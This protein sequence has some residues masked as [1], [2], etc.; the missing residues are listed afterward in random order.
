MAV[1]SIIQ[2][3]NQFYH[4]TNSNRPAIKLVLQDP[5]YEIKDHQ[6]L[7]RLSNDGD[8]I[9]FVSDPE[10]LLAIDAGT[11]VVTAFLPVQMP[12]VQVIADLFS[13]DPTEGPAAIICDIMTVDVEKREYSLSDRASPA[14]ARFLTNH[15]EKAEDGFDDHG[16]EDELM[17]DAYGD[18][19]ENRFYWLNWM[20]LWVRKFDTN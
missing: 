8:N 7:K 14:V 11:L 12:L 13:K 16:L 9:S 4:Q 15:Y 6:I 19:W 20:D 1:F 5:N 3:L 18:D 2:T 10:G 17:A